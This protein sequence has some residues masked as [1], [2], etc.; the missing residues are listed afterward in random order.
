MKITH[1]QSIKVVKNILRNKIVNQRKIKSETNVSLGRINEICQGLR[2]INILKKDGQH[3][4]LSDPFE[5]LKLI[6]FERSLNRL[7]LSTIRLPYNTINDCE[8]Y[9]TEILN[10]NTTRYAFTCFSGLKFYYEYH[11]S[12]PLIHVYIDNTN[13]LKEI[14]AGQGPIPV[15]FLKI[16]N[17]DIIEESI[18]KDDKNVCDKV[19]ILIDLYSSDLGKDAAYDFIKVIRNEFQ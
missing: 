13:I 12:Y 1:G 4:V 10:K 18:K 19:Q 6:S 9:L 11:I 8:K 2:E 14:E 7:E 3:Y 5:L 17:E 16:D 15:I